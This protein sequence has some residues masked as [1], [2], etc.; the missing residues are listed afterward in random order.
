MDKNSKTLTV[1]KIYDKEMK[2]EENEVCSGIATL[3]SGTIRE[4]D[5]ITNCEGNV[6]LRYIPKN[7]LFG[8]YDFK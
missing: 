5:V 3:P 4:G 6:A 2:W 8:A 1:Q 7:I